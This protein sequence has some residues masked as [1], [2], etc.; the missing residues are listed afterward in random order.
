VAINELKSRYNEKEGRTLLYPKSPLNDHL[1]IM[2][3]KILSLLTVVLIGTYLHG[4][5]TYR[6]HPP[7]FMDDGWEI[8]DLVREGIDTTRIAQLFNQLREGPNQIHSVV[9]VQEKK[10][11]VEEYF[12]GQE[13]AVPHDLRSATKSIRSLLLGIAIDKG[14][15]GSVH[16]PISKYLKNLT[17]KKNLDPRKETITI[18]HLMTMS[19]GWDCNDMDKKSVGQED[20]VYRKKDWLQYTLDLPMI[21]EPGKVAQYCSMG[22]ILAA[23][24]ISQSSGLSIDQFAEKFLFVPLGISTVNWGHTS[25]KPVIPS[26]KRLYMTSRGLAKLGQLVL[27]K[28]HWNGQQIVS[29]K[30]METSTTTKTQVNGMNY[31]YLWWQFTFPVNGRMVHS[32]TATGNGGQHIMIFPELDLVAVFTGGAYNSQEARLPFMIM[33]DVFLPA[34]SKN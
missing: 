11:V 24:I 2:K 31:G 3:Y 21:N 33:K 30:W 7:K 18:A 12:N 19:S 14:F 17:P 25:N 26:G 16:D 9:I 15:I 29:E 6:Y 13:R 4:Q 22:T 32:I 5:A 10:L 27:Q 28:G 34:F 20:K 23:E 1:V 8:G